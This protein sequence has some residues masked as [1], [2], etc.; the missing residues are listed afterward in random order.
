M[1][2]LSHP[3]KD[4]I[5]GLVEVLKRYKVK[6]ILFTGVLH[7]LDIYDEFLRIIKDRHIPYIIAGENDDK[8]VAQYHLRLLHPQESLFQKQVSVMNESS[9]VFQWRDNNT[10]ILFT[11]DYELKGDETFLVNELPSD[12]YKIPHHGSRGS[13]SDVILEKVHPQIAVISV[14]INNYG[15]P[16]LQTLRT[17]GRHN[18][19]VYQTLTDHDLVFFSDG[20][21]WEKASQ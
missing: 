4:H 3:E 2:A 11:G 19:S 13:V 12:I 8:E 20:Y 17:L 5:T 10:S 16:S 7:D 9:L 21:A 6:K 18:I 14:G 1:L 15:H